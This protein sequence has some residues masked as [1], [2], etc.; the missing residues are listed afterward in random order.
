LAAAALVLY[1]RTHG[2]AALPENLPESGP[3]GPAPGHS[4]DL[5]QEGSVWRGVGEYTVRGL[6]AQPAGKFHCTLRI[7][8]TSGDRFKGV[9]EFEDGSECA[10]LFE[11]YLGESVGATGKRK[12]RWKHVQDIKGSANKRYPV[13]TEGTIEG[14]MLDVGFSHRDRNTGSL[15][16]SG[17]IS[18]RIG[19]PAYP[20]GGDWRL[21]GDELIQDAE[22]AD[23]SFLFFGD[24]SW[25]DY[26]ISVEARRTQGAGLGW[27][28]FRCEDV[29]NY[30]A[31]GA[32]GPGD[33]RDVLTRVD[34]TIKSVQKKG[35]TID[36][37]WH[38]FKAVVRGE[39]I[40]CFLD[41]EPT[42]DVSDSRH[43]RGYVALATTHSA[44]R[45]RNLRVTD[46]KGHVLLDGVHSL[47]LARDQGGA[48]I[49]DQFRE[50]TI[51]RGR[52]RQEL[53]GTDVPDPPDVLIKTGKREATSFEGEYW[54]HHE[55][56]GLKIAGR[57]DDLGNISWRATDILAGENWSADIRDRLFTG[58]VKGK[59]MRVY[60]SFPTISLI[61][62]IT[63]TRDN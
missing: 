31:F 34:G 50:G 61:A 9:Y 41:D 23:V 42:F 35:W 52:V 55:T 21:D 1:L 17:V 20:H 59:Q 14:G 39:H 43:T 19:V 36:D 4:R 27:V 57:I 40:Q 5:V 45:F 58:T 8:D 44:S 46:A 32:W 38:R 12:I 15:V 60:A 28:V 24:P 16:G 10:S 18:F 25:T 6:P 48:A 3:P 54:D 33:Y 7:T 62:E 51:W 30:W 49:K 13:E 63:A 29:L 22:N 47:D 26:D 37:E 2:G 56:M 11:G 53:R